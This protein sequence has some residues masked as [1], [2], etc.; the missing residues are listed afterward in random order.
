MNKPEIL[1]TAR[2]MEEL[3]RV[4]Q[5]GADA[6]IIGESRWGMRLPGDFL[7]SDIESAVMAARGYGA[8]IYVSVNKIMDNEDLRGLPE[9]LD[10]L[11]SKS[12]DAII[13]GDPA[14]LSA[15]RD[16]SA[17]I[18][19]HWNAEMTSTNYASAN[20][21]GARGASRVVLAR[22]LNM[23]QVLEFKQNTTLEVQVQVHGATNIYHS[24]RNLI[25]S[26]LD[27]RQV[28]T[29]TQD[30]GLGRGL[31]LVEN[32]RQELS[33]PVYEDGG[34]TH[35]MSADDLCMLDNLPEL[36]DGGVDSLKIEGLLKPIAYNETV[37]RAYRQAVDRYAADPDR[38]EMDPQ[39]LTSIRQLQDPRRELTYGFYYKEQ[40]Y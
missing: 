15:Y 32:E 25:R 5:A 34:G 35:I 2:S 24:R 23:D 36:I 21:W 18:S 14:L 38:Y 30:F 22:E 28:Q 40:V 7:L 27:H 9:Y 4:L 11:L 16:L 29:A 12:V 10:A 39:W 13:F 17:T 8:K 6:V 26:Y 37:V 31:Y 3:H 1:T 20:Y 19:L 33:H